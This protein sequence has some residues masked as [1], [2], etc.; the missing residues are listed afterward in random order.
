MRRFLELVTCCVA[1]GFSL[2]GC[3]SLPKPDEK[4]MSEI[5]RFMQLYSDSL[6]KGDTAAAIESLG[7]AKKRVTSSGKLE[8]GKGTNFNDEAR[9]TAL[10]GHVE[11]NRG[12]ISAA[13]TKWHESF[14]IQ[15]N[16]LAAKNKLDALNAAMID[17]AATGF[18]QGMAKSMAKQSGQRSYT[19]TVYNTPVP[20]PLMISVGKPDGSVLRIPVHVEAYPFDNIV[21][22]NNN[23]KSSCTA[24]M[25]S[26]RVAISAAHCMSTGGEAIDPRVM[27]LRRVGI[28]PTRS[29][30]VE[31]YFTHQGSNQGWDRNRRND[32]LILVT[33]ADY[34]K[35][36][37][38]PKI[39]TKIP[40]AVMNGTE[41][42]MLA[43]YSSDLSKGFYLTLHYG[44][45]VRPGQRTNAGTFLTNCENAK[46]SSGAAVMTTKPPHKI[47]AIHTAQL[48]APKDDYYSVET[49]TT[50]FLK[51]LEKVFKLY[52]WSAEAIEKTVTEGDYQQQGLSLLAKN[53]AANAAIEDASTRPVPSLK[54]PALDTV[55]LAQSQLQQCPPTGRKHNCFGERVIYGNRYVGEFKDDNFNGRGVLTLDSGNKYAGDFREGTREGEAI[56]YYADGRIYQGQ[57][58]I[59]APHG[60]GTLYSANGSILHSGKWVNGQVIFQS[61]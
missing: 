46:G 43:G 57:W 44:C 38:F 41:K 48:V 56:Y 4:G 19:Y 25:I 24:T 23:S 14:D 39:T 61:N 6:N 9:L 60:T 55:A 5:P 15:Y 34:D 58:K 33:E 45:N 3:M 28:D 42:I 2:A 22:L 10:I 59:D 35:A 16:G 29:M 27:S 51:T 1:L 47:V 50:D 18:S 52:Q 30:R 31:Q 8:G 12:N 53:G 26:S 7:E 40:D 20:Q 21:K 36:G 37:T 11:F 17:G 54:R 32:W 13:A 49:F